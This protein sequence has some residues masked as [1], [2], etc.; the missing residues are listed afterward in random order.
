[1]KKKFSVFLVCEG[2]LVL[3]LLVGNLSNVHAATTNV[4]LPDFLEKILE[5]MYPNSTYTQLNPIRAEWANQLAITQEHAPGAAE[6]LS[7]LYT[8]GQGG[9]CLTTPVYNECLY[10]GYI[11]GQGPPYNAVAGIAD[12][13]MAVECT[14]SYGERTN[15]WGQMSSPNA[16]GYIYARGSLAWWAQ[17]GN[18]LM[19]FATNNITSHDP[20]SWAF[21]GYGQFTSNVPYWN[22]LAY[23]S[24]SYK[25][26]DF[27]CW[28]AGGSDPTNNIAVDCVW[29]SNC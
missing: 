24:T 14:P 28:A 26:M 5:A 2:A 29:T 17:T 15:L 21:L 7:P 3:L 4:T 10:G 23:N 16:G 6:G 19:V 22:Y 8:P 18:Y 13:V 27:G 12:D 20:S 25:Y 1:M 11:V 9:S